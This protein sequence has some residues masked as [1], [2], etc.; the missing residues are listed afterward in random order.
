M[1][2]DTIKHELVT[3]FQVLDILPGPQIRVHGLKV[4]DRKPS[5]RRVGEERQDMKGIDGPLEIGVAEFCQIGQWGRPIV[6]QE[7]P[8][9]Y[10]NHVFFS[11]PFRKIKP[12]FI[13]NY[14]LAFMDGLVGMFL[15]KKNPWSKT[16]KRVARDAIAEMKKLSKISPVNSVTPLLLLVTENTARSLGTQDAK[17]RYDEAIHGFSRSGILHYSAIG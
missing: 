17:V 9:G 15:A 7:I 1:V 13:V 10:K 12:P 8:I 5:V 6:S 11:E 4:N 14:F 16:G 2:D 3:I